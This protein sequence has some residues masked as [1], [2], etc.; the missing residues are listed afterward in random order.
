MR[1]VDISGLKPMVWVEN[2]VYWI[3]L[4]AFAIISNGHY[5][6]QLITVW[7]VNYLKQPYYIHM[8]EFLHDFYLL[9]DFIESSNIRHP[10][11]A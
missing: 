8:I 10:S 11:P 2:Q 9:V 4:D 3:E 7:I 1:L 5:K 6:V